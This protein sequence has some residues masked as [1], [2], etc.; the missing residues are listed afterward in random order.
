MDNETPFSFLTVKT[1]KSTGFRHLYSN[2]GIPRQPLA[3][4]AFV[5]PLVAA[6]PSSWDAVCACEDG[7]FFK[8]TN[9]KKQLKLEAFVTPLVAPGP[10]AWDAACACEDG[11][12]FQHDNPWTT[13]TP[14]PFTP[15][16]QAILLDSDISTQTTGFQQQQKSR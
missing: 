14:S 11:E 5:A 12:F 6:A 1:G 8:H 10:W 4:E 15:L 2:N 3:F 7:G 13:R 16:Y 9:P